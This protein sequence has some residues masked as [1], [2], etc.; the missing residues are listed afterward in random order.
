MESTYYHNYTTFYFN[1]TI[2]SWF[3]F[4]DLMNLN[5]RRRMRPILQCW[6]NHV[7]KVVMNQLFT[8]KD[9]LK[10]LLKL[11]TLR[12]HF[13]LKGLETMENIKNLNPIMMMWSPIWRTWLPTFESNF[14]WP[15]RIISTTTTNC[16]NF[17]KSMNDWWS[18]MK[19][20]NVSQVTT[21][22]TV[23]SHFNKLRCREISRRT[24]R[25][26]FKWL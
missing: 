7:T 9:D 13:L 1:F 23:S 6:N 5:L 19:Q 2:V 8:E 20:P 24:S 15:M 12:Q 3:G 17:Y 14:A 4:E 11:H 10:Y 16:R 26:R 25:S 18:N 22:W 21:T